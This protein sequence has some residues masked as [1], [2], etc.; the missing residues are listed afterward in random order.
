VTQ[1]QLER[2]PAAMNCKN[3]HVA[4]LMEDGRRASAGGGHYVECPCCRTQKY[5]EPA[6]ATREWRRI[7][8]IRARRPAPAPSN[9]LQ[10][11][12]RLTGGNRG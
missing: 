2:L 11:G 3:G 9:V 8:G 1:R 5:A 7:N 12:L 10:L 6:A 4:R